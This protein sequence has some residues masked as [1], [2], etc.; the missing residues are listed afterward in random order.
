MV[1]DP[2]AVRDLRR[3]ENYSRWSM[4][5]SMVFLGLFATAGAAS[6]VVQ[7]RKESPLAPL[8]GADI[9]PI[10]VGAAVGLSILFTAL[11]VAVTEL[12]F[13]GQRVPRPLSWGLGVSAACLALL[14]PLLTPVDSV[15]EAGAGA[16]LGTA[17]WVICICV[18]AL[19]PAYRW[20]A[21]LRGVGC[22]AGALG[23]AYL[24]AG[25]PLGATCLYVL[26]PIFYGLLAIPVSLVTWWMVD[27]VRRLDRARGVAAQLAVAEERLRFSRDLHDVFGRTLSSV[28]VKSE[29]AAE[30]ARRA[31]PRAIQEMLEV[32]ELAQRSLRD[33]RGVVRDYRQIVFAD[34]LA[35]ARSVLRSAG[36]PTR[37]QGLHG[38][39]DAVSESGGRA[40]AWVVRE[41]T[42]NI[43]RHASPT[44]V[45]FTGSREG[46]MAHLTIRND[47]VRRQK[48]GQPAG[49]GLAGLSERIEAVGGTFSAQR[50]GESFVVQAWVPL[51]DESAAD[52]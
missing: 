4:Y 15:Y 2:V 30:L 31:D 9:L 18:A 23:L 40:L 22:Y 50:H 13:R 45:E 49:T 48:A 32:R 47:R 10:A 19:S 34:E 26:L 39:S 43:L 14:S 25:H 20:R 44:C 21:L 12:L 7:M 36:I 42:T 5:I 3:F 8:L 1:R 16:W 52:E 6:L 11:A 27:V 35:G 38:F 29:L 28:A 37:V 17:P 41:A 46:G 33:V 24:A 51:T